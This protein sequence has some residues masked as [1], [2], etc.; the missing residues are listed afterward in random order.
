M[1]SVIANHPNLDRISNPCL[2]AGESQVE[3]ND[4]VCNGDLWVCS[5]LFDVPAWGIPSFDSKQN[6]HQ[7]GRITGFGSEER[8]IDRL[9]A[10]K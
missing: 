3:Q 7:S 4:L 9:V 5:G 6:C 8:R 2:N 1:L 10:E